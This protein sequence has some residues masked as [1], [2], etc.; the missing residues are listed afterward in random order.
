VHLLI[1][2]GCDVNQLD[3]DG[4][5]PLGLYLSS[6]HLSIQS[7]IFHLLVQDGADPL[8]INERGQ[9][10]AHLTMRHWEADIAV[11]G[12]LFTVGVDPATRD[13]DGKTLMHPGAIHGVFTEGL[14]SFLDGEGVLNLTTTECARKLETSPYKRQKTRKLVWCHQIPG[15]AVPSKS[16][17]S[18]LE[19]AGGGE[20]NSPLFWGGG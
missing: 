18:S 19:E 15:A 17:F 11:L 1:Q 2:L 3:R 16:R 5:S 7:E 13:L 20:P 4:S 6:F 14:S 12:Y 8:W 9:T 10:L